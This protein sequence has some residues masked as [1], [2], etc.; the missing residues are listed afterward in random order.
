MIGCIITSSLGCAPSIRPRVTTI[1]GVFDTWV[2][3][4]VTALWAMS[5]RLART[6]SDRRAFVATL[7]SAGGS[8]MMEVGG[9]LYRRHSPL[10]LR[11]KNHVTLISSH[12][13]NHMIFDRDYP[14][15]RPR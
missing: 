4:S 15:D 1:G 10:S 6:S 13:P 5:L 9:R 11:Y 14:T 7:R 8:A 3:R 2:C 12:L